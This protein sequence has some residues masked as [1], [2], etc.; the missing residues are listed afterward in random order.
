MRRGTGSPGVPP[1]AGGLL[2]VLLA[3]GC[4]SHRAAARY[5]PAS[6][7]QA[8]EALDAWSAIRR[9][10]DALPAA[11]LLY[12]ARLGEKGMPSVPGTLAVTYDGTNVTRA[13]LTGPFGKPVAE[14]ANGA[15][16]GGD[17][18]A[19]PVDPRVLRSV[20]AAAWPG[21]P[22]SVAGCDGPACLLVFDGAI[23]AE[24]AVDPAAQRLLSLRVTG[25][26]G[27]LEVVYGEGAPA[28]W[29]PRIAIEDEVHSRSLGLR[30][31]ASE[32][33]PSPGV[34]PAGGSAR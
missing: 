12:D 22:S 10:A 21:D 9:R 28:P 34:P 17:G 31:V 27:S 14:Y 30:L 33:G 5:A 20:L 18:R 4:A 3:A 8:R 15:L 25:D 32:T 6:E 23:R 7:A 13:S 16:V 19:F 1:L 29:P 2:L 24:A 11:R 26:A